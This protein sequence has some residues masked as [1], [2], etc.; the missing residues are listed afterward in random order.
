MSEELIFL[1]RKVRDAQGKLA[2]A[3]TAFVS[4]VNAKKSVCY[5]LYCHPNGILIPRN[6]RET[7]L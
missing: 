5:G 3:Q 4:E 2:L 7:S 1:S 6:S